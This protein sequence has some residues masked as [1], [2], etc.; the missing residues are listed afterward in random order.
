VI[1]LIDN[2][3]SF[4][5]NLARY[6]QRLGHRTHVVRNDQVDFV[7]IAAGKFE[8]VVISPGPMTP[9]ES[10]CSVRVVEQF[11][12]QLPMLGI[13]LGHQCMGTAFGARIMPTKEP[14]HGRSSHIDHDGRREFSELTN[15]FVAGR[16]HSLIVES[17]DVPNC[18]EMSAWIDEDIMMGL[19]HR[20]YPVMGWQFHPESIMTRC[21]FELLKGFLREAGLGQ[22]VRV[23]SGELA[24][25]RIATGS[26]NMGL[27][28]ENRPITF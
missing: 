18:L 7:A 22:P 15:P 23:L 24:V 2:Y 6:F 19:R 11:H 21:G 25:E 8:A 10:G 27:P 28:Y 3:D 12:T 1:L 26:D 20:E 5:Y 16:Y 13:C 14:M 9:R 17:N 4:V